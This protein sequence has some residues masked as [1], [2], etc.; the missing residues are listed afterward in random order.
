MIIMIVFCTKFIGVNSHP[1]GAL[2]QSRTLQSCNNY[3]MYMY[4]FGNT[5]GKSRHS[6]IHKPYTV[7]TNC[8]H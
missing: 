4:T 1:V 3:T 2:T 7:H 5:S 8:F 6:H